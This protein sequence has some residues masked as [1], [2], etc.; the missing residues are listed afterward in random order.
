MVR[1]VKEMR[2]DGEGFWEEEKEKMKRME[3]GVERGREILEKL[4]R[5]EREMWIVLREGRI[6]VDVTKG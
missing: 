4:M 6:D 5:G 3:I 2:V 1:V